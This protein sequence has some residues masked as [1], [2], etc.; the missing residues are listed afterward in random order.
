M[1]RLNNM[2]K[3]GASTIDKSQLTWI[4]HH[5]VNKKGSLVGTKSLVHFFK[6]GGLYRVS[7]KKLYTV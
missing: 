4:V 3:K 2:P 1:F 6:G 7:Q 5:L